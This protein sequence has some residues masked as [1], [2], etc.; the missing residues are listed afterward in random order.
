MFWYQ[1]VAYSFYQIRFR[2][3]RYQ[4]EG[5][6]GVEGGRKE[7]FDHR[8][9]TPEHCNRFRWRWRFVT[10]HD[11]NPA[12][13]A[14]T[15]FHIRELFYRPA[16]CSYPTQH[17]HT[18]LLIC[19]QACMSPVQLKPRRLAPLVY[20]EKSYRRSPFTV[21]MGYI[22]TF[23]CASSTK[24]VG[25]KGMRERRS[26]ALSCSIYI[27]LSLPSYGFGCPFSLILALLQCYLLNIITAAL[28]VARI[29]NI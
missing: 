29:Q 4:Y 5:V 21:V 14:G 26:L 16:T 22:S 13:I 12:A 8:F 10:S 17:T 2:S 11:H 7:Y 28:K 15:R 20:I 3:E 25:D 24:G 18:H 19:V 27:H 1:F 23:L 9:T 6:G